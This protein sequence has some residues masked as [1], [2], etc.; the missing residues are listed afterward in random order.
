MPLRA[1]LRYWLRALASLALV[2]AALLLVRERVD[3]THVALAYLLV[4]LFASSRGGRA[5]GLV[6]SVA[7]F[8]CFNFF[9]LPPFYHFTVADPLDWA[10]LAAFLVTSFVAAQLLA[11]ARAEA[12]SAELRTIEVERLSVLG[13]ETLNAGRAEDALVAIADVIRSTLGAAS[14]QVH[15]RDDGSGHSA[16]GATSEA[17]EGS[18]ST[19]SA[20]AF[21]QPDASRLVEWV[22]SHGRVAIQ[23]VDGSTRVADVD[24]ELPTVS[25]IPA[26]ARMLVIPLRVRR[27]T[28]GVLTVVPKGGGPFQLD[29]GQRRFLEALSYYAAL[30]VER[31]RLAAGAEEASALRRADELKNALLASVSHDLRTPLTTIKALAHEIGRDGDE[32]AATIEEEADRLNRFVADLLDLSRIAGGAL[33]V[34]PELNAAEDLIGAALQRVGGAVSDR[35]LVASLDATEPLLLGRF[36]FVH[37]LRVL[38]NLIENA[39]EFAPAGSTVEVSARRVDGELQFTVADRGEGVAESERELIFEPFYREKGA[40]A[41]GGAGLGLSI[42]RSLAEAQR[43]TVRYEPRPEGGSVFVF[44][45]PAADAAELEG[46]PLSL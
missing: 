44:C 26:D 24:D 11:R 2:T 27:R 8:L 10:V 3:K 41:G 15:V 1:P 5:V 46:M 12:A 31:V 35:Q 17:G 21:G 20:R 22:A 19:D 34:T 33:R 43:G 13:A 37:S 29:D 38:A 6:A 40:V 18:A 9:F 30:G 42:A 39:L 4:V 7:A 16:L 25:A 45:V 14:A 28:V 32:R 23:L 36:D